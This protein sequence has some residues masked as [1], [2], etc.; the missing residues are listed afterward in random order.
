MVRAY[1]DKDALAQDG[2]SCHD[3][4]TVTWRRYADILLSS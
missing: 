1:I 3:V 2:D 4:E